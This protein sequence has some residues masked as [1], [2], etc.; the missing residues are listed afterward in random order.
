VL[1]A[2][3]L[4][5]FAAIVFCVAVA[6]LY[7]SSAAHAAVSVHVPVPFTIVTTLPLIVHT[8]L[9][10]AVIVGVVL[11]FVVV[12]TANVDKYVSLAGAPVKVTVGAIA[13]ATFVNSVTDAAA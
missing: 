6:A 4:D 9:G 3:P 7:L 10:A 11:A 2:S 12:A 1:H 13:A 5:A 8:V